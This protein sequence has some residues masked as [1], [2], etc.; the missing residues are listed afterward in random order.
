MSTALVEGR[1]IFSMIT[2]LILSVTMVYE[3]LHV[4]AVPVCHKVVLQ[5][6]NVK[7]KFHTNQYI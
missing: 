7:D 5:F 1:K 6:T 3:N 4:A 2:H